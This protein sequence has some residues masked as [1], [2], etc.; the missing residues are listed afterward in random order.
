MIWYT[1]CYIVYYKDMYC[2]TCKTTENLCP[3]P[4]ARYKTKSYY[5]CRGCNT[6]N[7]RAK[8]ARYKAL[9]YDHYGRKCNCCGETEILFLSVD[10]VNNDGNTHKHR[11]G[12]RVLGA[13][14]YGQIV[15]SGYPDSYQILCMNCNYGK[16]KNSGVCPHEANGL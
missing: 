1:F 12:Q 3:S 13:A 5:I 2:S 9:V 4:Y 14:L 16:H 11:S 8:R 7:Q 6:R 15:S 10:H